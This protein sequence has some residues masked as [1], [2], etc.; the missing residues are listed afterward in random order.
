MASSMTPPSYTLSMQGDTTMYMDTLMIKQEK[1]TPNNAEE[2]VTQIIFSFPQITKTKATLPKDSINKF[3]QSILLLDESGTLAY[4]SLEERMNDFIEDYEV[5]KKEL[6]EMIGFDIKWS[7]EVHIK[8]LLNTPNL[9]T[10]QFEE[11]TFTGGNHA[12]YT[13]RFFNFNVNNGQ[14]ISADDIFL[15]DVNIDSRNQIIAHYFKTSLLHKGRT[16]E[17]IEEDYSFQGLPKNFGLTS[18]GILFS[19]DP[20]DIAPFSDGTIQFE[21]PY[22][23]LLPYI[24]KSIIR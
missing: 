10:L 20:Y 11:T 9:L 1:T 17:Q 18:T 2:Q 24:Q 8:V 16:L 14:R 19:F 21:V 15:K 13:T 23:D 5:S 6:Y 4:N 3:I 7:S 22:Y 12:N